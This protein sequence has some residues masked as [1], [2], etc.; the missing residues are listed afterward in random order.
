MALTTSNMMELG[1]IAPEFS[2]LDTVSGDILSLATLR[3]DVATVIVFICN[4]CP[5]VH[6]INAKLVEVSSTYQA[7]GVQFIGISSNDVN[8][9]PQDGPTWMTKTALKEGYTFPYLYDETQE[10]AQAYGA[11]CTPDFF[12]FNG[13]LECVYR[14]RFDETRPGRGEATGIDLANALDTI[15]AGEIMNE[16]QFPSMGCNIK[17]K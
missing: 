16:P 3:S 6:H 14:G 5:F 8:T 15:V 4:H 10:V 7:M 9:H 1:S 12:V 2:L 13:N 17:W 11:Q